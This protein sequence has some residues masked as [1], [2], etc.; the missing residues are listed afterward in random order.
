VAQIAQCAQIPVGV[1]MDEGS[2]VGMMMRLKAGASATPP[3]LPAVAFIHTMLE[4]FERR[5][6]EN[7]AAD[8]V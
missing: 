1:D 4:R 6:L 3:T 7:D 5:T 8:L 2:L